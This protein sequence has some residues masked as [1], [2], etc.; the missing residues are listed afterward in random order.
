MRRVP[1]Y[2]VNTSPVIPDP[3]INL[4]RIYVLLF[5]TAGKQP[6]ALQSPLPPTPQAVDAPGWLSQYV[7][8][9]LVSLG[10]TGKAPDAVALATIND[11]KFGQRLPASAIRPAVYSVCVCVY[12]YI[13]PSRGPWQWQRQYPFF[14]L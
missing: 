2:I 11:R 7:P 4:Q 10:G 12:S 1:N 13:L 8:D 5:Y 6:Y 14:R 9:P 3:S